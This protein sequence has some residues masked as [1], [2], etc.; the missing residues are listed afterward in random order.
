M[1]ERHLSML[2]KILYLRQIERDTALKLRKNNLPKTDGRQ[3][4]VTFLNNTLAMTNVR[5]APLK[6]KEINNF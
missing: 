6:I 5:H 2:E 1:E 3:T 4:P